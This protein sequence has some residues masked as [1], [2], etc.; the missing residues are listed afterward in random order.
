MGNASEAKDVSNSDLVVKV[1]V[2]EEKLNKFKRVNDDIELNLELSLV[3]AIF[4]CSKEV[5]TIERNKAII[6]ISPGTQS[7]DKFV[8]KNEVIV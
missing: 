3:D 6:E 5:E 7:Y 8:F 4:G 1:V 2:N